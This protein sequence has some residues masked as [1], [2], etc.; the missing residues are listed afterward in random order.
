[1]EAVARAVEGTGVE[2]K[3]VAARVAARAEE[4]TEAAATVAEVREEEATAAAARVVAVTVAATAVAA[5]VEAVTV[6]AATAVAATAEAMEAAETAEVATAA[7]GGGGGGDGG[8]DSGGSDGGGGDGGGDGG[9]GEGGDDGALKRGS[10]DGRSRCRPSPSR[11]H[12]GLGCKLRGPSTRVL[13]HKPVPRDLSC[14][15]SGSPG[16]RSS[17]HAAP[18]QRGVV[19]V[20]CATSFAG[21]G[22]DHGDERKLFRTPK[23]S[24]RGLSIPCE[25][26]VPLAAAVLDRSTSGGATIGGA[27][28]NSR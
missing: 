15:A 22:D 11:T 24:S 28:G 8:G 14:I 6:V 13:R 5:M 17:S 4:G 7:A 10:T 26:P 27:V 25:W 9:G 2:G 3:E 16:Q 19:S 12:I 20:W 21:F 18:D 1:M 23:L